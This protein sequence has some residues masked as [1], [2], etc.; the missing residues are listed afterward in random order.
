[1]ERIAVSQFFGH[2]LSDLGVALVLVGV[3]RL[4]ERCAAYHYS[5]RRRR[6]AY[7]DSAFLQ[8]DPP[9]AA[10]GASHSVAIHW[11]RLLGQRLSR[12]YPAQGPRARNHR[13]S[14]AMAWLHTA[15]LEFAGACGSA[16][17]L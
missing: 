17:E 2:D 12:R 13:F 16:G 5:A 9:M 15:I 7:R 3:L 6:R 4:P 11:R 10:F 1:M 8:T 14:L